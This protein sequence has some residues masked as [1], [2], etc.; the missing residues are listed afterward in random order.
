M[1]FM[2]EYMSFYFVFSSIYFRAYLA[3]VALVRKRVLLYLVNSTGFVDTLQLA[4]TI[5]S[6]L[7]E[8]IKV[9]FL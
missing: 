2:Y 8:N 6:V 5:T 9:F 7:D 4:L 3:H 1:R